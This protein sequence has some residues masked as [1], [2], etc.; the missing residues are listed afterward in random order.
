M[1]F[2]LIGTLLLF[3]L[4][5]IWLVIPFAI[6]GIKPLLGELIEEQRKTQAILLVIVKNTSPK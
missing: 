1:S 6:F 5:I 2:G 4:G 3:I